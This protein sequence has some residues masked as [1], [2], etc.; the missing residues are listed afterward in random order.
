[1]VDLFGAELRPGVESNDVNSLLMMAGGGSERLHR[2]DPTARRAGIPYRGGSYTI[3]SIACQ[4]F[5]DHTVRSTDQPCA[6]P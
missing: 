3:F 2:V 6:R 4:A 5:V 1:M